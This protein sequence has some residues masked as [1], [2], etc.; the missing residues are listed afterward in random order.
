ML[1]TIGIKFVMYNPSHLPRTLAHPLS[2]IWC[3][4]IPS[5]GVQALAQDA[6]NDVWLN[7][8]SLSFPFIGQR[9][10]VK[11][12]DPIGGMVLSLY[13]IFEWIKTLLQ[14][15]ANCQCLGRYEESW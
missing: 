1:A 3:S 6:E 9:L 15:F 5:S 8:M 2:W 13:I 4:R 12:L 11:L 14:N 7:I 10:G